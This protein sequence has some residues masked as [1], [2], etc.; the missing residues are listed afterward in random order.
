MN[1]GIN[2]HSFICCRI[3]LILLIQHLH[4]LLCIS[5]T[6][7]IYQPLKLLYEWWNLKLTVKFVNKSHPASILNCDT[8]LIF[9]LS[10][11]HKSP[12]SDCTGGHACAC[13]CV[14]VGGGV[15]GVC[16]RVRVC[17]CACVSTS[18]H[19]RARERERER[20]RERVHEFLPFS[21]DLEQHP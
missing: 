10:L 13:E 16:V 9:S 8:A 14:C 19:W 17:V 7:I 4:N 18:A 21:T 5:L 6:N 2:F 15:R 20:E 3:C 11:P 12:S 1:H